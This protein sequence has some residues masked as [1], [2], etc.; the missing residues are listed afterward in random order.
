MRATE[1]VTNGFPT[2]Q[3]DS[4]NIFPSALKAHAISPA[5]NLCLAI[6]FSLCVCSQTPSRRSEHGDLSS[7]GHREEGVQ[8]LRSRWKQLLRAPQ[9]TFSHHPHKRYVSAVPAV[10]N[11]PGVVMSA[12]YPPRRGYQTLN[13]ST[14]FRSQEGRKN[15]ITLHH[16]SAWHICEE[17][18]IIN[19]KSSRKMIQ[20]L[21]YSLRGMFV[22]EWNQGTWGRSNL[23]ITTHLFHRRCYVF[24]T[25]MISHSNR[26][27]SV[28]WSVMANHIS[29]WWHMKRLRLRDWGGGGGGGGGYVS[30]MSENGWWKRH[31]NEVER[32]CSHLPSVNAMNY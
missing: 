14:P 17:Y 11:L 2:A 5:S 25:L 3:W 4:T 6:R 13:S 26:F 31:D 20:S 7:N 30:E 15:L 28:S 23:I 27:N 9:E 18:K 8:G 16:H 21:Y 24:H 1:E 29:R 32:P 12:T 22:M 19:I 10:L